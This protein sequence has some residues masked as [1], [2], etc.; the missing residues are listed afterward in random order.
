[1]TERKVIS[2][3]TKEKFRRQ[4]T[5]LKLDEFVSDLVVFTCPGCGERHTLL[6]YDTTEDFE[7]VQGVEKGWKD[8]E[9]GEVK[10]ILVHQP[11][12]PIARFECFECGWVA[13][14]DEGN[15]IETDEEMAEWI[16]KHQ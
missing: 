7:P 14:D 15:E 16:L 8:E 4:R 13:L 12:E 11:Y 6:R 3:E 10:N 2:L 9:T 1:M 5:K